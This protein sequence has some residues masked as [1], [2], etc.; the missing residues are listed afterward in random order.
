MASKAPR[1]SLSVDACMDG[2]ISGCGFLPLVCQFPGHFQLLG[3]IGEQQ[4]II[5]C[6]LFLRPSAHNNVPAKYLC[7]SK[8][9]IGF[10][11]DVQV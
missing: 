7:S 5:N 10:G 9:D 4:I 3:C 1:S 2:W 6:N 8:I 11:G